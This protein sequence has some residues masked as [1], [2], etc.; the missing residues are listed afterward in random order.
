M[1]NVM[2]LHG[3]NAREGAFGAV[4]FE[5]KS[6]N[7]T[8]MPVLWVL[9]RMEQLEQKIRAKWL[10]TKRKPEMGGTYKKKG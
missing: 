4:F 10:K 3:I 6:V 1:D 2:V 7:G 5:I 8:G 9:E